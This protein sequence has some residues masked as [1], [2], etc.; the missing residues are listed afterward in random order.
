MEK[1][2]WTWVHQ[3]KAEILILNDQNGPLHA[4]AFPGRAGIL[5]KLLGLSTEHVKVVYE[6]TGSQK[7]GHY[8]P[9]T[10][11][12][13]EPEANLFRYN[14]VDQ[15]EIILNLAWHLPQEVRNNLISNHCASQV[16]DIMEMIN[17]G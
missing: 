4:K 16:I 1:D 12:P 7:V 10:K 9:G 15:P 8:L 6:I 11:I 14:S 2:I 3:K 5:I 17:E 13:I